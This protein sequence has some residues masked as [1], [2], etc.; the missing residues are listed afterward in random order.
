MRLPP[1]R[2]TNAIAIG[3]TA[4]YLLL[5][6]LGWS[7]AADIAGGFVPAR[8]AGMEIPGAL[9]AWIT[10]LTATLLHGGMLHLGFNMLML[11]FCGRMVEAVIG[12]AA[13]AILYVVGAYVAAGMQ[14][15]VNPA[16][17][18]PMIGAS[19]AISALFAGYALLF[20]RPRGFASHPTLGVAIN[21]VWLAAAWI[22]VQFLMGFAFADYGMA[23]ATG[24]HVGGF[25]AGLLLI[26]PLLAWRR[27]SLR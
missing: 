25:L 15:L 22:G 1:S 10:P 16:D 17:G 14:F 11:V 3:T 8:L 27:R 18:T 21:I 7:D 26:R 4:I 2:C 12:P 5:V 24:A 6:L 19:G 23:I 20:G 13:L 9:P